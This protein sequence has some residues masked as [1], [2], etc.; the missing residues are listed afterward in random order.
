LSLKESQAR[1]STN[2]G[3]VVIAGVCIEV[4][5]RI[6]IWCGFLW[7]RSV[8][9]FLAYAFFAVLGLIWLDFRIMQ[10]TSSSIEEIQE[11]I[12]RRLE[13]KELEDTTL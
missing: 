7:L 6:G 1:C 3:R 8:E 5:I 2:F 12:D 9:A 11:Y 13:E 10:I 4:V